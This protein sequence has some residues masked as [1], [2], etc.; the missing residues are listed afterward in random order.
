[1]TTWLAKN[2]LVWMGI[3]AYT[4]IGTATYVKWKGIKMEKT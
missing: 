4:I 3:S 2:E 1:M